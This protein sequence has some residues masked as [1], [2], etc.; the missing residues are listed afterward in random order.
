MKKFI[1]LFCS[2]CVVTAYGQVVKKS[3]SDLTNESSVIVYAEVKETKSEWKTD[4]LGKH[5]RTSINFEKI[6]IIRGI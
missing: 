1:L 6:N 2:F 3:I 4:A 5:I